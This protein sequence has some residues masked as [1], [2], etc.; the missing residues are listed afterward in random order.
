MLQVCKTFSLIARAFPRH[1]TAIR[2]R[3]NALPNTTACLVVLP[4]SVHSIPACDIEQLRMDIS[5][6]IS[7]GAAQRA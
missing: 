2:V 1:D 4:F 3:N 7:S 6:P 5:L